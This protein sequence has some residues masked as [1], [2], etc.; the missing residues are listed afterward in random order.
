MRSMYLTDLD[1]HLRYLDLP[2]QNPV[3]VYLHGLG[4]ASSADFPRIVRDPRLAP[5]RALLIDLLGYGFSDHPAAF[6]H[7]LTTHARAVARLLD[8]LGLQGC[9]VIGHSLGGSIAIVLAAE[10]PD[11]V[12]RLIVAEPN[13]DAADAFFSGTIVKRWPTEEAYLE[14]GHDTLIA[15]EEA[16][17]R[18]NPTEPLAGTYA[19]TLHAADPRAVYRCSQ[20][21]VVC[22]L[23]HTFFNLP[24]TRTYIYGAL[25]LPHRHEAWLAA[26]D[27]A[28]AVVPSAGH[29]MPAEQ[30]EAFAQ[31]LASAIVS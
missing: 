14:T 27:I 19:G 26:S 4:A 18:A 20:A 30:P 29:G 21:L 17:A 12:A 15:E 5:Y 9:Q 2:G 23:R 3:C 25:T 7:T 6:P 1:A 16:F 22:E 24:M 13:L 11:L 10:R 8:N 31:V 28:V